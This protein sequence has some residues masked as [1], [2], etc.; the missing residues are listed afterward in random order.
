MFQYKKISD[1]KI[2]ITKCD[3]D[4]SLLV[5]PSEIDGF[6]V[7]ELSP[8]M[9]GDINS[10]THK[11]FI[12]ANDSLLM[13]SNPFYRCKN[14]ESID[15]SN[16]CTQFA[17]VGGVLYE[18]KT[19]KIVSVPHKYFTKTFVVPDGIIEIGANA[20]RWCRHISTVILPESIEKIDDYAFASSSVT[21]INIPSKTVSIGKNP[22]AYNHF[23]TIENFASKYLIVDGMLLSIHNKKI[24][25][26]VSGLDEKKSLYLPDDIVSIGASAFSYSKLTK[27]I[28][29][30]SLRYIEDEA[31]YECTELET[32]S[33][34]SELEYIGSSC[35]Y[36]CKKLLS[37]SLNGS[38]SIINNNAFNGCSNL[39]EVHLPNTVTKIDDYA[40]FYCK[41]LSLISKLPQLSYIGE[42]AFANCVS[43]KQFVT[44]ES[45]SYIGQEAFATYQVVNY[46]AVPTY[47]TTL[48]VDENSYSHKYCIDNNVPFT[49]KQSLSWLSE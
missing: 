7:A 11:V 21:K 15:V 4:S 49:I 5:I 29:P 25:S 38:V 13:P 3:E 10:S 41:S 22:F 23:M 8:N 20:F 42:L 31:F 16:N 47:H 9:F 32:F 12:E 34:E 30:K 1:T 37:V 46:V 18:K 36:N 6:R 40:F 33:C 45:L 19:K 28:C 44:S 48:I 35:F 39:V 14:L 43:L 17:S 2:V 24:I 26:L 27:I